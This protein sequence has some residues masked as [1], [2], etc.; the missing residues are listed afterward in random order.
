M[1]GIGTFTGYS[2]LSMAAALPDGG[3]VDTCEVSEKHAEVASRAC[4]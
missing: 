3:R 4:C 2:A 1:L